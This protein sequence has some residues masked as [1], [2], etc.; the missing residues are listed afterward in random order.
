MYVL[1]LYCWWWRGSPSHAP[2]C[3]TH[4]N[5]QS[6][7]LGTTG[8]ACTVVGVE[9]TVIM[10][11]TQAYKPSCSHFFTLCPASKSSLLIFHCFYWPMQMI[12]TQDC[13]NLCKAVAIRL[14]VKCECWWVWHIKVAL[15]VAWGRSAGSGLPPPP[16]T[17]IHTYSHTPYEPQQKLSNSKWKIASF[18]SFASLLLFWH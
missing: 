11:S 18:Q 12:W 8:N 10:S 6:L 2:P 13:R 17:H 4:T 9:R 5:T 3:G 15:G 1:T 7:I 16:L 14:G